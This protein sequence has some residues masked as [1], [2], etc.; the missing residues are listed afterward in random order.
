MSSPCENCHWLRWR[1]VSLFHPETWYINNPFFCKLHDR[2][3]DVTQG[4]ARWRE[5]EGDE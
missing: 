2:P 1:G 5:Q 3:A 4:C